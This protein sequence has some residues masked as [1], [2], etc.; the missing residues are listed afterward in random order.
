MLLFS[1]DRFVMVFCTEAA[2]MLLLRT[3][4]LVVSI[5]PCLQG[6]STLHEALL[7]ESE[8]EEHLFQ[9][10]LHEKQLRDIHNLTTSKSWY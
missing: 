3:K 10:L 7:V 5:F 2:C 4:E 9:Q 6:V 8:A 1:S